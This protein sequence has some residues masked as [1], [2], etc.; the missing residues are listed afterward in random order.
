MEKITLHRDG[1][2]LV[3]ARQNPAAD[4]YDMALI[5]HGFTADKDR[6][7]LV[8]IAAKLQA[9]NIGSL[10]L[11]FNGHGES[12]GKLVNM[13]APSEIAD[14]ACALQYLQADPHVRRIF[15]LGHSLGGVVASMLAGLYPDV[16]S[17]VVL[18]APAAVMR[19][20]AIAGNIQGTAFDP[21]HVPAQIIVHG[22]A[23]GGLYVR[24]AQK[25]PIF[26]TA[27]A[28]TGPVRIIHGT[29]DEI[30]PV[31]YAHKYDDIYANSDLQLVAGADHSFTGRFQ[32]QASTL[33]VAWLQA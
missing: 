30:V 19:A 8:E 32:G 27:Q 10:R 29:N 23:I 20:D 2:K 26:A 7:L 31:D 14:A 5:L 16:I 9:A 6:P 3:A 18:L 13:T 25:L 24:T 1:L 11:D 17:K 12:E 21:H 15:V 28:F 22:K 4:H 33:A